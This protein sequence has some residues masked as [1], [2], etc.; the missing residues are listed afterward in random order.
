MIDHLTTAHTLLGK[1]LDAFLRVLSAGMVRSIPDMLFLLRL[2]ASLELG[3]AAAAWHRANEAVFERLLWK[4]VGLFVLMHLVDD[5]K[6]YIDHAREGFI[7]AGLAIG[8]NAISVQDFTD[9]GNIIDFGFSVTALV[10]QRIKNL[11]WWSQS[12]EI[13]YAGLAA[14]MTVLFYVVMAA[15]VFKAILEY[16]LVCACGVFLVPF[17]AFEKTA[18]IGERVFSTILAHAVRL[19][20][21]ALLL[22]IALPIL[23]TFKLPNDPQM[24]EVMLLWG[25]SFVL[26]CLAL[27]AQAMASGFLHGQPAL[28]WHT[29][30]HGATSFTQTTA[31]LGAVGLA[32]SYGGG[33]LVESAVRA[34]TAVSAAAQL[35]MEQYRTQH[36]Y[37]H[38]TRQG[39][40][41]T[42]TIGAVQGVAQY[43]F[44]RLASSFRRTAAEGRAGANRHYHPHP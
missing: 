11:S 14:M 28:G 31:A 24:Q 4:L 34:G 36:P 19:M 37:T 39:Q 18:F 26:M 3:V 16:Y 13:L 20:I 23:Y 12:S 7:Q 43:S 41:A 1:M 17:V 29:V 30:L 32:A 25:T 38:A 27:G 6:Y 44:N 2:L 10:F 40:L 8:D 22:N 15:A 35:G 42:H 33:R 5:W 9:P 21:L